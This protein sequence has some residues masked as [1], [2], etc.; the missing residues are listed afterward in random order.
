MWILLEDER[1]FNQY[2]GELLLRA[3]LISMPE[4]D[5]YLAKV[6]GSLTSLGE[7]GGRGRRGGVPSH[8]TTGHLCPSPH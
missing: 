3:H 7:G 4:M 2:L 1:K 6:R 8:P 5:Q